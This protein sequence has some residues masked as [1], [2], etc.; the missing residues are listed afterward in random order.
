[1]TDDINQVFNHGYILITIH[2]KHKALN[3]HVE[4]FVFE[5]KRLFTTSTLSSTSRSFNFSEHTSHQISLSTQ[6]SL[7]PLIQSRGTAINSTVVKQNEGS[8]TE[9][10][11]I[12]NHSLKEAIQQPLIKTVKTSCHNIKWN[13]FDI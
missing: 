7:E 11:N 10:Q 13:Y 9:K 12:S 6:G 2:L 8:M 3:F 4:Y 1:M 5:F